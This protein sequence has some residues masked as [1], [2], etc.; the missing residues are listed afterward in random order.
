MVAVGVVL[1][2]EEG[3]FCL[4]LSLSS[5]HEVANRKSCQKKGAKQQQQQQ[6]DDGP[7]AGNEA[8]DIEDES[9]R[10]SAGAWLFV[11]LFAAAAGVGAFLLFSK[12]HNLGEWARGGVGRE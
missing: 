9:S 3:C 8:A 1:E 10:M 4:S 2:E 12:L 5:N 7:D 11:L 6:H